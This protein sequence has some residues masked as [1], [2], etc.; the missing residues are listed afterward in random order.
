MARRVKDQLEAIG[1]VG[2]PDR[3]PE[4]DAK[5]LVYTDLCGDDLVD[6]FAANEKI[7]SDLASINI[8][9]GYFRVLVQR[10]LAF[11]FGC[12]STTDLSAA[13]EHFDFLRNSLCCEADILLNDPLNGSMERKTTK[14]TKRKCRAH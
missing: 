7:G 5:F 12:F 3:T 4:G 1:E 2:W 8:N 10:P 9:D 13:V 11:P 6:E 14:T